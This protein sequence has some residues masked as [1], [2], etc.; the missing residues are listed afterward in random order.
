MNYNDSSYLST[1]YVSTCSFYELSRCE[2]TP[3]N[4][5][6]TSNS[7][8][9]SYAPYSV[10]LGRSI[11]GFIVFIP[12]GS[13]NRSTRPFTEPLSIHCSVITISAPPSGV[14]ICY[15]ITPP[16]R[17]RV[18]VGSRYCHFSLITTHIV[19]RTFHGAIYNR[20]IP[21]RRF[22]TYGRSGSSRIQ[23][24]T[25]TCLLYTSPSPRD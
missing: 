18:Q 10:R 16:V 22:F 14:T 15:L 19:I 12:R 11:L 13:S 20:K 1:E 3:T 17:V 24:I 6:L 25:S 21:R 9:I 7:S 2:P 8:H 5:A 4:G 23:P